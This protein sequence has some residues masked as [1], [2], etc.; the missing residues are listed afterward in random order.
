MTWIGEEEDL[1]IS[2]NNA[3]GAWKF[4]RQS[5]PKPGQMK[6]V[7]FIVQYPDRYLYIEFKDPQ[8]PKSRPSNLQDYIEN[9]QKGRLDTDLIYKYR[10]TFMYEWASGR[11]DR[12][13]FYFVLIAIDSLTTAELDRGTKDLSRKLPVGVPSAWS[14][15]LVKGC[16]V[17]NIETWNRY[18]PDLPI[19][20][21]STS[22]QGT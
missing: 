5:V 22:R 21:L 19:R 11:A 1:E 10:D 9:F 7:D 4:D 18:F 20:R 6:A 8:D 14:R 3:Q 13:I 16:A 12:D 15:S 17:F 2:V